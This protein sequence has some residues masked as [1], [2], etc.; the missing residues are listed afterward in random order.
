MPSLI[1]KENGTFVL[2][3]YMMPHSVD[4]SGQEQ[5]QGRYVVA[6][7]RD[8]WWVLDSVEWTVKRWCASE[9]DAVAARAELLSETAEG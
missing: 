6:Y 3:P 2:L 7:S 5:D 9:E 1:E 4:E 8:G